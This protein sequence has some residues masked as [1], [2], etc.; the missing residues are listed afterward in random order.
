MRKEAGG[1]GG[2]GAGVYAL[3]PSE[4]GEASQQCLVRTQL[5]RLAEGHGAP[6][7]DAER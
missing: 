7:R 2:Q 5:D 1:W 4:A 6:D 3:S